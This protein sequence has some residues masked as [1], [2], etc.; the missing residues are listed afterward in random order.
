M[1][2]VDVLL[3]LQVRHNLQHLLDGEVSLEE[4][5]VKAPGGLR[6]LPGAAGVSRLAELLHDELG[7][8]RAVYGDGAPELAGRRDE[9]GRA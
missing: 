5:L 8:L 7:L 4:V 3:D 1:R 9:A 6:V 2:H